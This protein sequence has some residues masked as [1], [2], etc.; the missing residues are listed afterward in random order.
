MEYRTEAIT[1]A[2][3]EVQK[4]TRS[5]AGGKRGPYEK[6]GSVPRLA[7]TCM[8]VPVSMVQLQQHGI[9]R[10]SW[11][12][13]CLRVSSTSSVTRSSP[14]V[15]V[16]TNFRRVALA[17]KTKQRENFTSENFTSENFLIYGKCYITCTCKCFLW[18]N[19]SVINFE[20]NDYALID[21]ERLVKKFPFLP[22]LGVQ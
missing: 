11:R 21:N 10:G 16:I 3:K 19:Q 5:V 18:W 15:S 1:E 14:T 8:L 6:Y 17:M 13:K 22:A 12:N 7:S 4:A 2:N 9:F 20:D